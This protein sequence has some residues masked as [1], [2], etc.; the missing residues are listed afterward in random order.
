MLYQNEKE[1]TPQMVWTIKISALPSYSVFDMFISHFRAKHDWTLS[2]AL[3][4]VKEINSRT[5]RAPSY[6]ALNQVV[7]QRWFKLSEKEANKIVTLASKA[8]AR[9]DIYKY[10]ED[11]LISRLKENWAAIKADLLTRAGV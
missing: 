10:L 6:V 2:V 11:Q 9:P 4:G 3:N 1:L 7:V 5:S 8:S